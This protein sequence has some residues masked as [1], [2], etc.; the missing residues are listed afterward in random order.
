[1]APKAKS[2]AAAKA[3]SGARNRAVAK[4]K[5]GAAPKAKSGA[6]RTSTVVI[7]TPRRSRSPHS[8][9]RQRRVRTV[10]QSSSS[11][12]IDL[13][14]MEFMDL[15]GECLQL[16]CSSRHIRMAQDIQESF[17]DRLLLWD[18]V[19][20][21]LDDVDSGDEVDGNVVRM[22]FARRLTDEEA[23]AYRRMHEATDSE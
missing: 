12:G 4:A 16:F 1:M 20:S 14:S 8:D 11:H 18:V 6:R 19:Y 9:G 17:P 3:K 5:S 10:V 13:A 21:E 15:T 23:H 2:G 22:E 7:L